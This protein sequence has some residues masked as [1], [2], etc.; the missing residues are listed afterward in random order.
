MARTVPGREPTQRMNEL[1]QDLIMRRPT[2]DD[3]QAIVNPMIACDIAEYGEPDSDIEDL[4][5][6]WQSI[7]LEQDA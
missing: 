4:L 5:Y 6:D 3:V 1:S 2:V 7:N